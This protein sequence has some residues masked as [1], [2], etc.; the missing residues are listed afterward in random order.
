VTPPAAHP[1]ATKTF[2]H[3]TYEILAPGLYLWTSANRRQFLV[4]PFGTRALNPAP[5]HPDEDEPDWADP[6]WPDPA[7][8]EPEVAE[9]DPPPEPSSSDPPVA[10]DLPFWPDP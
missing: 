6:G 7:D 10:A 5:G 2:D 4:G 3:W 1:T 9:P 8:T